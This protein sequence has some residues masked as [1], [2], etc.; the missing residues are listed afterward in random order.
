MLVWQKQVVYKIPFVSAFRQGL[1]R[2]PPCPALCLPLAAWRQQRERVL[3]SSGRRDLMCPLRGGWTPDTE[4]RL[5]AEH[6]PSS[7][8][9]WASTGVPG[10][11]PDRSG[12]FHL[13]LS[14]SQP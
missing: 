4:T 13:R 14:L 10:A 6:F 7:H 2:R 9:Y 8:S 12:S 3:C 11:R 1:Q 5:T